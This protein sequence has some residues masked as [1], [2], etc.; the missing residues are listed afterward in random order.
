METR[1]VIDYLDQQFHPEYQEDYDN[2]GFLFGDSRREY[3]GALVALD[4]T[5]AVVDEA[6]R[7]GL[8]L[9]VSHHPMIFSG[10]KRITERNELG[11]MLLQ[12]A[13]K[14]I[15]VYAAHTNLDNLAWGV[16]GALAQ[17][18]GLA[19]CRILKPLDGRPDLGAGMVGTLKEA[20]PCDEYLLRVKRELGLPTVRTSAHDPGR[21]VHRVAICGGSGAFLVPDAIGAGADLYL[22][23]DLKYH[24]F[25]RTDDRMVLADVGHYESEQFA[26]DIIFRCISEKFSTFACRISEVQHGL[27]RYI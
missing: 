9:I 20:V 27:V 13:S 5:T 18:L 24:D 6:S 8:N 1:E 7:L 4:V 26:K 10:V 2:S 12:L 11:Q 22:T 17:R 25:Q 19:D 14:G 3:T 23:A 15:C 21:P 16:N